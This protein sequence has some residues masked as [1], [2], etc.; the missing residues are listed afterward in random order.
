MA[1]ETL[2][3]QKT[4]TQLNTLLD[5]LLSG[6]L[7]PVVRNYL[8]SCQVEGKSKRTIEIY[9]MVLSLF[10]G[11]FNPLAATAADIR[12]FLLSLQNKKPATVHIY[13]RS[14]KTFYN[15]LIREKLLEESPMGNIRAPKL[16]KVLI[17]P[18]TKKDIDN[19]MLL[20]NGSK[21]L[22]LRSRAMFLIFLD[23]GIRLEEMVRIQLND[24]DFNNETICIT[25]KGNKER[26]V[27]I[28]KKTQKALFK[29]LLAR[30]DELPDLWLTEEKKS[31]TRAGIKISVERYC[32][33]AISSGARPSCHTFRHTAA[34][35][36]L[37]NGGDLFTLQ[38][39]LGHAN[40]ETTRRYASSL[41]IE[42]LIRVHTKASPV[43]NIIK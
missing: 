14:I 31:M 30:N 8:I 19:L 38:I 5:T 42:D 33:R 6:K 24:L 15:W 29:Y 17:H 16:P 39:M 41:G 28:G 4:H 13:Y 20:C 25:G 18:F 12:L 11:N 35:L 36:Y 10:S 22:D 3:T 23:T 37:R 32:K 34:I 27:R 1:L 40:L 9:S 2:L 43:D 7:P 26:L 21:F